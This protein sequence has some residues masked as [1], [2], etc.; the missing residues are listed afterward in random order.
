MDDNWC[1]SENEILDNVEI[2]I[3][4]IFQSFSLEADDIRT[5]IDLITS[6]VSDDMN[7]LLIEPFQWRIFIEQ[8]WGY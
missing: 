3:Q 7:K 1:S 6:R 2:Y 8:C 5:I 4:G